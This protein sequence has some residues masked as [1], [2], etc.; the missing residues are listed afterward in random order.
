MQEK[1]S[2]C[3]QP[4]E[5]IMNR[6]LLAPNSSDNEVIDGKQSLQKLD[7]VG[8]PNGVVAVVANGVAPKDANMTT[9]GLA[10]P[11]GY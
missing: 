7:V 4:L 8:E 6:K 5:K 3:H 10:V 1:K 11:N 2:R 9:E